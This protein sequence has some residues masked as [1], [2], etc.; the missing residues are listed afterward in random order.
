M[1]MELHWHILPAKECILEWCFIDESD[2]TASN[3]TSVVLASGAAANDI[4]TVMSFA[5]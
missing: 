5:K 1:I 4:L 3:G 2:I